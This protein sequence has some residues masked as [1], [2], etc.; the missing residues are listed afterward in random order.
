[1]NKKDTQTGTKSLAKPLRNKHIGRRTG[2]NVKE[3]KNIR[4]FKDGYENFDDYWTESEAD[5]ICDMSLYKKPVTNKENVL[6]RNHV[7]T[8]VENSTQDSIGPSVSFANGNKNLAYLRNKNIGRRTGQDVKA[9][10]D[11][12]RFKDGFENFDDYW[13]E[14]DA[15]SILS[16]F[17][18]NRRGSVIEQ[19]KS[20][21]EPASFETK[22]SDGSCKVKTPAT[23]K[24]LS[25]VDD[26]NGPTTVSEQDTT[27][28]DTNTAEEP[29]KAEHDESH[30]PGQPEKAE[31]AELT[32]SEQASE[33]GDVH[34]A[35]EQES[36]E[37][38]AITMSEQESVEDA[39][40]T[41]SEQESVEDAPSTTS[42]QTNVEDAP[43]T[44]S[45][46]T[47]VEVNRVTTNEQER[48][49]DG[50]SYSS[51]QES[52]EDASSTASRQHGEGPASSIAD[53]QRR[54]E[55]DQV[56]DDV[57]STMNH[58]D[59]Q[60]KHLTHASQGKKGQNVL[61]SPR[62]ED[63]VVFRDE[64]E[65]EDDDASTATTVDDVQS[66]SGHPLS[67]NCVADV[68]ES[69]LSSQFTQP[70][71]DEVPD[72]TTQTKKSCTSQSLKVIKSGRKLN[73]SSSDGKNVVKKQPDG[74]LV[75]SIHNPVNSAG[76][77]KKQCDGTAQSD[78]INTADDVIS[79]NN[80]LCQSGNLKPKQNLNNSHVVN[81][82]PFKNVKNIANIDKTPGETTIRVNNIESIS[83][84]KIVAKVS[85]IDTVSKSK[86]N[87]TE[88]GSSNQKCENLTRT[89]LEMDKD[90]NKKKLKTVASKSN[91]KINKKRAEEKFVQ[92]AD[93]KSSLSTR[94][95]TRMQN[96]RKASAS[97]S[98][99]LVE[100]GKVGEGEDFEC[101]GNDH[102][103]GQNN[104]STLSVKHQLP[105]N[106]FLELNRLETGIPEK[107]VN[108]NSV[109]ECSVI[110]NK[111]KDNKQQ[112]NMPV[113]SGTKNNHCC[114]PDNQ[115][116]LLSNSDKS[117]TTSKVVTVSVN[118]E[119]W[120][121]SKA[122]AMSEIEE[123]DDDDDDE[124]PT[125]SQQSDS[126]TEDED[127][128]RAVAVVTGVR[129]LDIENVS[130]EATSKSDSPASK[131]NV[132]GN[133]TG[134]LTKNEDG[135]SQ[136]TNPTPMLSFRTR[137]R[138]SYS[139]M[140]DTSIPQKKTQE[141]KK[142]QQSKKLNSECLDSSETD[143][144]MFLCLSRKSLGNNR[145]SV[146]SHKE[147]DYNFLIVDDD[148]DNGVTVKQQ[149]SKRNTRT[150][151]TDAKTRNRK[152]VISKKQKPVKKANT[153]K[154]S[155]E[156]DTESEIIK[157]KRNVGKKSSELN[158]SGGEKHMTKNKMSVNKAKE[159][160]T[161]TNDEEQL[162]NKSNKIKVRR[163]SNEEDEPED[164]GLS[165]SE[166]EKN[167]DKDKKS[168]KK[169][170]KTKAK[171]DVEGPLPNKN[172]NVKL[173][174]LSN[175]EDESED[176]GS[177]VSE[178]ENMAKNKKSAN[179]A[180]KTKTR[181]ENEEQLPN[182]NNNIKVRRL[183]NEDDEPEPFALSD[184]EPE[185][186]MA[187]NKKSLKKSKKT[188]TKTK[189]EEQLPNKNNKIKGRRLSNEDDE[190]EA[191]GHS[192][193]ENLESEKNF[194]KNKK[195]VKKS[196][197]TKV[198][199]DEEE[200][201][202]NKNNKVKG[203][204][205]SNEDDEPE[206]FGH[207]EPED[208]EPEKN[209]DK[210]KKSVKK[211]KKT[212]AKSDEEEQLPNKNNKVKGRRLSNED[213]EPE[214]FGHSEPEDLE[215]DKNF[216]K[217][218]KSVKK[219]KKTKAK[220]DKEE[221]LPNKNNKIKV[222]RLS[223]EDDEPEA[224]GHSDSEPEKNL[225]KNKKSVK[226][227]KKTKSDDEKDMVRRLSDEPEAPA[228]SDA[229]EHRKDDEVISSSSKAKKTSSR[230][231]RITKKQ[232]KRK[233]KK[234]DDKPDSGADMLTDSDLP[235]TDVIDDVCADVK[236]LESHSDSTISPK[237]KR[238]Y[239]SISDTSSRA[240]RN[241]KDRTRKSPSKLSKQL[242][243]N[244]GTQRSD[245]SDCW[246]TDSTAESIKSG[247]SKQ[248]LP[249]KLSTKK[250]PRRN[251][252]SK[253][254]NTK[255]SKKS[256]TVGSEL[257]ETC[258]SPNLS[259]HDSIRHAMTLPL[260]IPQSGVSLHCRSFTS[261]S[262]N[263]SEK[264]KRSKGSLPQRRL[265]TC[266]VQP[267]RVRSKERKQRRVTINKM[268]ERTFISPTRGSSSQHSSVEDSIVHFAEV[269]TSATPTSVPGTKKEKIIFPKS[270]PEGLRRS[271][272]TRVQ[273]LEWYK[274]ERLIYDRR[275]SGCLIT[276]IQPSL[277]QKYL[278]MQKVR[279]LKK[280]KGLRRLSKGRLLHPTNLSI[281]VDL[282]EDLDLTC[283]SDV[284][285]L[286]PDS[287]E[288][289]MLRC[290]S[291]NEHFESITPSDDDGEE[292]SSFLISYAVRQ[293]MVNSGNLILLPLAEKKS[294]IV[295][296]QILCFCVIYGKISVT[297]HR[298]TCIVETGNHFFIPR[299]NSYSLKNLRNEE[300]KLAFFNFTN[301]TEKD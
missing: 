243:K 238:K 173:K 67:E 201:L 11:I 106:K 120:K 213:D 128:P 3:G 221:Q 15:D 191:F 88:Q 71:Q 102:F 281:H 257:Q 103:E 205:L 119:D 217:N 196:K 144:N 277:E 155:T 111:N 227:S 165:D 25:D 284:P 274:N 82:S 147:D 66:A 190:P 294:Q 248:K 181:S 198:K 230:V 270:A 121:T 96:G 2:V 138:L 19:Q 286:N 164:F 239:S 166:P 94:Q 112:N 240:I 268:V 145:S 280:P 48:G 275:K 39:P 168:V 237:R 133:V 228:L 151:S 5:S 38:A 297:I 149:T 24:K 113:K 210:N 269:T 76:S 109:P 36:V 50:P 81:K 174:K 108:R 21:H 130:D 78:A 266:L 194:D 86:Q 27:E 49:E 20:Q 254:K 246:T 288:E 211:S 32:A 200:Q 301:L 218:K 22:E 125:N 126:E 40:I 54:K 134:S 45:E 51:D 140:H 265:T 214:A 172:N 55:K 13:S 157:Q 212:K 169:S 135:F 276:G 250:L 195:S 62:N 84:G 272:R 251:K 184:S 220:S 206:A 148:S 131:L 68:T 162:S 189:D 170:K 161:K 224:F 29:E 215:P 65:N 4:K 183:S 197:K 223:N 202:P 259:V 31:H 6:V 137:K 156:S 289:M 9:G 287:Q 63:S 69:C 124:T 260:E 273:T 93:A 7:S 59:M 232:P 296:S 154:N 167:L 267:G 159:S 226:K 44:V 178:L 291:K 261:T 14:S 292:N 262:T 182:K 37:D 282:P 252:L 80:V 293:P 208:L 12:R 42:G 180:K 271:Q 241:T 115:C 300:A 132:G 207:S 28:D 152:D 47:N 89:V 255:E 236:S 283:S 87:G 150:K 46:Q 16:S 175:E 203:R 53:V 114:E 199:S 229:G 99:V 127:T 100:Q 219:S 56:K 146:L 26:D 188:K 64:Q 117:G 97:D 18:V 30:T 91:K 85:Q 34:T 33:V 163:L 171:S 110:D 95:K 10:K 225:D 233:G 279:R 176:F 139:L 129:K 204:R 142:K 23:D 158:V 136:L 118:D 104:I 222:R 264:G 17:C 245:S 185:K 192:E 234:V 235:R 209:F 41:T 72:A 177:S 77:A 58:Q 1:M 258:H 263:S 290:F 107:T 299:G 285:I 123:D 187:K 244:E 79:T 70:T 143:S 256:L 8:A 105:G 186:N 160:K 141:K 101:G 98:S 90:T 35:S 60:K 247:P 83:S 216:D 242:C 52:M 57:T 231:P 73:K 193:P 74:A 253:K 278:Q 179:K 61:S 92:V 249:S 298:A 43:S 153:Q 75:Q 122:V 116:D 295:A